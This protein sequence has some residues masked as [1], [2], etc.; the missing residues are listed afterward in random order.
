MGLKAVVGSIASR[1]RAVNP[2]FLHGASCDVKN[3]RITVH[4]LGCHRSCFCGSFRA[5]ELAKR[6]MESPGPGQGPCLEPF[7]CKEM[8]ARAD[9]ESRS[10]L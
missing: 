7:R 5:A 1:I 6:G 9:G 3:Q 10:E 4:Y 2:F 8:R